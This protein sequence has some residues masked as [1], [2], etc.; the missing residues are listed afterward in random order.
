MKLS[1]SNDISMIFQVT[2]EERNSKFPH[3]KTLL[4]LTCLHSNTLKFYSL[5]LNFI[6]FT[7][8]YENNK[9]IPS[10]TERMIRVISILAVTNTT[11]E[12]SQ[13]PIR[14]RMFVAQVLSLSNQLWVLLFPRAH[15]GINACAVGSLPA[16]RS[17]QEVEALRPEAMITV[18]A[19]RR[20]H[21]WRHPQSWT[22]LAPRWLDT[23]SIRRCQI[24]I[25]NFL[26]VGIVGEKQVT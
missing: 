8:Y 2:V 18:H 13:T 21:R 3:F 5:L 7:I 20:N 19:R 23:Q 12:T 4:S 6:N 26:P 1:A 17:A 24:W 25:T 11:T 10:L 16:P 15:Q 22:I 14:K 9:E